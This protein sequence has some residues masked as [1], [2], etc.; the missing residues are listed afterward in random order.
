MSDQPTVICLS[1]ALAAGKTTLIRRIS[2]KLDGASTLLFDDYEAYGEWPSD[3]EA[4]LAGGCDPNRVRV[5]RLR[6]DVEALLRGEGVRHPTDDSLIPPSEI[7]LVEDPFGRTRPDIQQLY[8]LVLYV[9]LPADLS[10]VRMVKRALGFGLD[11]SDTAIEDLSQSDLAERIRAA[12]GWLTR[13]AAL[14][15]MYTVLAEPVRTSAD[16]ILDGR[17]PTDE[18]CKDALDALREHGLVHG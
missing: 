18:L 4:W 14:R 13:Y 8:D 16:V 17:K 10:V 3:M 2:Q 5:P 7:L 11:A 6:Q 1:G 15:D 12:H 9:G